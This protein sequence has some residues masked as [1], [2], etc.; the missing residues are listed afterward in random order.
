MRSRFSFSGSVKFS[1][2]FAFPKTGLIRSLILCLLVA[3]ATLYARELKAAPYIVDEN[4]A[5]FGRLNQLA[6]PNTCNLQQTAC[7]PVATVNSFIYLQNT[8]PK[9]YGTSLV[10]KGQEAAVAQLLS[11]PGFMGCCNQNGGTTPAGLLAGKK[12]YIEGSKIV[13]GRKPGVTTYD[14]DTF[15]LDNDGK[16]IIAPSFDFLLRQLN[17]PNG[18]PKNPTKGEDVEMILGMYAKDKDGKLL[19]RVTGHWVTVTGASYDD[20]NNDNK[21]DAGDTPLSISFIDPMGNTAMPAPINGAIAATD[22][23]GTTLI[24]NVPFLTA[25]DYFASAS[26]LWGLAPPVGFGLNDS[27]TAVVVEGFVSESPIPEPASLVLV[28]VGVL[29]LALVRRAA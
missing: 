18:P 19:R 28:A 2:W 3:L 24:N 5:D 21:F 11:G 27:N 7:G 17:P 29:G 16:P 26:D 8:Y 9:I 22:T 15:V 10:P 20:K 4:A 25:T 1:N 6:L 23:L 13:T 12:T 14:S